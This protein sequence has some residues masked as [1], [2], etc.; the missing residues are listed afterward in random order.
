MDRTLVAPTPDLAAEVAELARRYKRANGPVMR[1]VNRLGG[2]F[3]A[4]LAALP[5]P[6][7]DQIERV[8]AQA[9]EASYGLAARA[10]DLGPRGPMAAVIA[11]G[12]AGGAGGLPT[13]VAE[14]PVTVTLFLNAIRVE[15]RAAGLD[16]DEP[17]VR[18]E[19]LR[20]F[21]AGSPLKE[22]DGINTSFI[23]SRLALTGSAVR[24]LIATIAPRL[25]AALGQKLAAQAIPVI[26]AV[27]GATLN[28]A[29][30]GYYREVARVRFALVRL[31]E[32]HGTE[33]VEAEFRLA[34]TPPKVIRA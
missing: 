11:T 27:A 26:G 34:T 3:E 13:A 21:S 29:Y 9:L 2:A 32:V 4:Q 28:A 23:G 1:L 24:N 10:P 30:L 20:V 18:A 14:L 19:C 12:A 22:D 7:R 6:V 15:A 17:W 5:E 33:A 8:T 25:A 31:A 16:P